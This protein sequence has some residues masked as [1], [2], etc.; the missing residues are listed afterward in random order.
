MDKLLKNLYYVVCHNRLTDKHT[1]TL[2]LKDKI[3]DFVSDYRHYK[4]NSSFLE[5]MLYEPTFYYNGVIGM[6]KRIGEYTLK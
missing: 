2:V 1:E 5:I 3:D 6:G 4:D